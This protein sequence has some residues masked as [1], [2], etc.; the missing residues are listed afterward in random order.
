MADHRNQRPY[1][2][3]AIRRKTDAVLVTYVEEEWCI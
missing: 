3:I 2:F 1:Y